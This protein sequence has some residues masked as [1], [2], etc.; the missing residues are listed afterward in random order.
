MTSYWYFMPRM[1]LKS[2]VHVILK[3][4]SHLILNN[5]LEETAILFGD[6]NSGCSILLKSYVQAAE[7]FMFNVLLLW[8]KRHLIPHLENFSAWTSLQSITGQW[9]L[10]WTFAHL[11]FLKTKAYFFWILYYCFYFELLCLT[12]WLVTFL[13]TNG[14]CPSWKLAKYGVVKHL[15]L[16]LLY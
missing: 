1:V 9:N 10:R 4:W 3:L 12:F 16:S 8:L 13:F 7:V 5:L 6:T 11:F 14:W 2:M 15:W